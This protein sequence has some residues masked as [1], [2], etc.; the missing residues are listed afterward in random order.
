M[1]EIK[2]IVTAFDAAT[3]IGK[4]S[5]LATV[6][7]VEGSS[8]R[9]PGARMLV[10]E[11]GELTGA[12]SG[13]CL[14]GDA[15]RK[16]RLVISQDKALLVTYDTMDDDDATLG[17]GLGC[18]GI[19]HILIEPIPVHNPDH[20]IQKLREFLSQR[21]EAVLVTLFCLAD[22]HA[23]QPGTCLMLKASGTLKG[24]CD[25]A[26]IETSVVAEAKKVLKLKAS[27]VKNY[28]SHEKHLTA[29]IEFLQPAVSLIIIGAG[30]DIM[31]LVQMADI[32][33]W[34]T[35]VVDGRPNYA[36]VERF[37]DAT[38]VLV[39]KASQVLD[40]VTIDP[41]TAFVL[42]THN[43][44]Y[45]WEILKAL[46]EKEVSYI[47][48]LGPKKKMERMIV[49]LEKANVQ[50]PLRSNLYGPVGLDIGAETSE[51]I[52]LSV[53]SEIK[54]VISMRQGNFLRE[55]KETIHPRHPLTLA[56]P[57]STSEETQLQCMLT[58]KIK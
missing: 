8:Y 2:D 15:L 16:A 34:E 39:S 54:A 1:K 44:N 10:T 38:R 4:K 30:N 42:M 9:R 48:V 25:D 13:G 40:Q 27:R 7:H 57:A 56:S 33:A 32:L 52:A 21:Q 12:I 28:F 14:E 46:M 49:D 36:T 41:Q 11:D 20:P 29:F 23:P 31:P 22:R 55:K 5:A 53:L 45:D 50:Q 3:K 6:V 47:G 26:A 43:Y 51:E 17:V 18:N 24:H 35:T 58:P 37:P 19:I